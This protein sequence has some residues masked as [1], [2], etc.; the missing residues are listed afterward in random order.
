[1]V[2]SQTP[3]TNFGDCTASFLFT[4]GTFYTQGPSGITCASNGVPIGGGILGA[5]LI[6]TTFSGQ[7][8][9]PTPLTVINFSG[10]VSPDGNTMSLGTWNSLSGPA[11]GTWTASRQQITPAGSMQT[12]TEGGA[13]LVFVGTNPGGATAIVTAPTADGTLPSSFQLVGQYY[14]VV[15][16]VPGTSTPGSG[17]YIFCAGY[18]DDGN[19]R[20]ISTGVL[21]GFL[22]IAHF[23][24]TTLVWELEPRYEITG[25]LLP[26]PYSSTFA[27]RV[28]ARVDHLSQFALVTTTS[29]GGLVSIVGG[30][31]SSAVG[32]WLRVTAIAG[33]ATALAGA[34][35]IARRRLGN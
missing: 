14:H 34:S 17:P 13:T 19:G 28:C 5:N 29:V 27:N 2:Y 10:T 18:T 11:T 3:N 33:L 22:Q 15:T 4:G 8:A 25:G 7:L 31:S 23:N 12:V 21:E 30:G 35:W 6:G 9:F 32:T 26:P 20:E 16:T 24:E 1:M